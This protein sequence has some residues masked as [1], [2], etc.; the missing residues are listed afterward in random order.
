MLG[1]HLIPLFLLTVVVSFLLSSC[2]SFDKK[3]SE[4]GEIKH[5]KSEMVDLR[6]IISPDFMTL[7]G[8]CLVISSSKSNPT[9]FV[10]STP[11]LEFM[12]NFGTKG[13]GPGEIK[14]FPMFCESPGSANLY[15]W[16]YSPITIK[17]ISISESGEVEYNE[18]ITLKGYE[19]FNNMAIIRDS[20]FVFY[21]PDNLTVKKYDLVNKNESSI[22]LPNDN[23]RESYFYSNRG[24]IA[25][26]GSTLVYSYLFK[27]QI[28]IYDLSTLKLKTRIS[29]GEKYPKPAP[30]DFSSL[31]YHY[32][33]LYA[34]EKYFYALYDG[35]DRKTVLKPSA[36]LEVYDYDGNPII[37]YSFDILPYL[38]VVDEDNGKIYGFN[39]EYEDNLLRY[40]LK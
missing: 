32:I 9:V 14:L 23:H 38:F 10:Y 25:T 35:E 13:G 19:A 7:K 21:L 30:G 27:R 3:R 2:S 40:D 17:K 20:I 5:L 22:I 18:D 6:E 15:V 34:G 24:Y 8:N 1:K 26:S 28:D 36:F 4:F 33:G 39:N 16:G 31:I 11:S 29:D 12:S 37:K